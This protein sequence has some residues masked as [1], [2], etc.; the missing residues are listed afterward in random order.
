MPGTSAERE[1]G[2]GVE[3]CENLR[4]ASN[5]EDVD[6]ACTL[7]ELVG[8]LE[9]GLDH[10]WGSPQEARAFYDQLEVCAVRRR[11]VVTMV[12]CHAHHLREAGLITIVAATCLPRLTGLRPVLPAGKHA[13]DVHRLQ[14]PL[15]IVAR[16]GELLAL[17]LTRRAVLALAEQHGG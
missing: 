5:S 6:R 12:L 10:V 9:P 14:P 7:E 3:R 13:E 1:L 2:L 15:A 17:D 11:C 8:A 16:G 4:D